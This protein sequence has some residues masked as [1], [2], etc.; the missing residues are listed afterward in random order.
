[1]TPDIEWA[2]EVFVR[3]FAFTRSFTHPYLVERHGAVWRLA[4]GPRRRADDRREEFVALDVEPAEVDRVARATARGHFAVCAIRRA[5]QADAPI[6]SGY[7][8]LGYRL[9]TTEPFMAHGLRRVPRLPEPLPLC[10][11][12][13][14][15][16]ADRLARAARSR[17][18]LPE[19]LSP[20]SALRQ[21]VA[22]DGEKPV[23]WVRSIRVELGGRGAKRR[24][25]W[26][27]S[28]WVEPSYRRRGIGRSLLARMLRDDRAGGA[29]AS[30]L[31]ASHSG[32]MLYPHVGYEGIGELLMFTRVRG[33]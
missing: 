30:V 29:E 26:V 16:L 22:L 12:A 4:D 7:K 24:A 17:Q 1:M 14:K 10:R 25:M 32:A 9:Q 20:D 33:K 18:V 2:V 21:Y 28:M 5:D 3:G 15:E 6:R 11:V 27:S 31:L 13:T 19:H 23:G 8:A